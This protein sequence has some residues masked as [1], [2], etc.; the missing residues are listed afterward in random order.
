MYTIL[1]TLNTITIAIV[2]VIGRYTSTLT[3]IY[4]SSNTKANENHFYSLRF[5]I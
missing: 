1:I 2:I 5:M 4:D 3:F